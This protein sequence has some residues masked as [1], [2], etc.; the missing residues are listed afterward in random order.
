MNTHVTVALVSRLPV[1]LVR[2]GH[3]SFNRLSALS[4]ALARSTLRVEDMEEYAELQAICAHLYSLRSEEFEHVLGTFPLIPAGVREAALEL[5]RTF[6]DF[7][8]FIN[9][10]ACL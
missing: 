4:E 6:A 1:P 8:D 3:P 7:H 9:S 2:V 10:T 5:S